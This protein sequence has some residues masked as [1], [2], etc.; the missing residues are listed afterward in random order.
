MPHSL[1][2]LDKMSR[3]QLETIATELKIKFSK[4]TDNENLAYAI[5]DAEANV[6][7][8]AALEKPEVKKRGRKPKTAQEQNTTSEQ[9]QETKVEQSPSETQKEIQKKG[10]KLKRQK[11][12]LFLRLMER[13]R[14]V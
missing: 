2:E 1:F 9:K 6:V 13:Y 3:E 8:K 5:L 4:K 14:S 12:T 10:R 7:A 11:M